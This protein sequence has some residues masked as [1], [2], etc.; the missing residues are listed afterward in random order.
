MLNRIF[1]DEKS[2]LN[3]EKTFSSMLEGLTYE[4]LILVFKELRNVKKNLD[5]FG[6]VEI[7]FL[8]IKPQII[9]NLFEIFENYMLKI[10]KLQK[11]SFKYMKIQMMEFVG[12]K[13]IQELITLRNYVLSICEYYISDIIIFDKYTENIGSIQ[14]SRECKRKL[15]FIQ[16]DIIEKKLAQNSIYLDELDVGEFHN[17]FLPLIGRMTFPEYNIL[18]MNT[19]R[20]FEDF[21]HVVIRNPYTNWVYSE[22]NSKTIFITIKN[23]RPIWPLFDGRYKNVSEK[24]LKNF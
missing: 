23:S 2:L 24:Q 6:C 22:K 7:N 9:Y 10:K 18:A 11:E 15:L 14:F 19:T 5:L 3:A 20:K 13:N 16:L 1:R 8:K 17:Y 12:K 4:Y 21:E